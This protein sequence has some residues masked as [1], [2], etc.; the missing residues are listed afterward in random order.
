M[1]AKNNKIILI[2]AIQLNRMKEK[3][4]NDI[5]FEYL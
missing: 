3:N 2:K 1:T 4:Q 5:K